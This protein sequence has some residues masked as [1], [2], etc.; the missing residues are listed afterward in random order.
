[1]VKLP[2]QPLTGERIALP[3]VKRHFTKAFRRIPEQLVQRTFPHV[4]RITG[5]RKPIAYMGH[6]PYRYSPKDLTQIHTSYSLTVCPLS[7]STSSPALRPACP[8]GKDGS[9]SGFKPKEPPYPLVVTAHHLIFTFNTGAMPFGFSS[10]RLTLRPVS[11][12]V[13]F[14][15]PWPNNSTLF[16]IP[17]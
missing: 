14:T 13:N 2:S 5:L 10:G 4:L 17:L 15:L 9:P 16:T 7:A 6:R 12:Q 8:Q 3:P 11:S 1:M